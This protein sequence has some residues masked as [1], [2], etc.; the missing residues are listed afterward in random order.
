MIIKTIE[1]DIRSKFIFKNILTVYCD[2]KA[3]VSVPVS[4]KKKKKQQQQLKNKKQ[5]QHQQNIRMTKRFAKICNSVSVFENENTI[6]FHAYR[7][8]L[9]QHKEQHTRLQN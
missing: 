4:I 2:V 5:Q 1:Y 9:N 3:I 7:Y 6:N 8:L